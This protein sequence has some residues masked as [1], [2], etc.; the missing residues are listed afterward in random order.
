M[1]VMDTSEMVT[2]SKFDAC[3]RLA[4]A[5]AAA[6]ASGRDGFTRNTARRLLM[7]DHLQ[8]RGQGQPH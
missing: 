7:R 8:S 6:T 3:K 2:S 5:V 4:R 1:P